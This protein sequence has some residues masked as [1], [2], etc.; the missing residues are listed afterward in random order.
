MLNSSGFH[1]LQLTFLKTVFGFINEVFA[2]RQLGCLFMPAL[3]LVFLLC[4]EWG[5]F[6][7]MYGEGEGEFLKRQ[8]TWCVWTLLLTYTGRVGKLSLVFLIY[9]T[10]GDAYCIDGH[11]DEGYQM[12]AGEQG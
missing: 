2:L 3:P 11:I 4:E 1:S 6:G 5:F 9:K 10:G 12:R 7:G 8:K